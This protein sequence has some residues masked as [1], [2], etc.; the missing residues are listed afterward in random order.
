[1]V[2]IDLGEHQ[3]AVT[4]NR[5]PVPVITVGKNKPKPPGSTDTGAA[6][7]FNPRFNGEILQL[8][9]WRVS[10]YDP[11]TRTIKEKTRPYKTGPKGRVACQGSRVNAN[12]I[13]R[14]TIR[15]PPTDYARR[16]SNAPGRRVDR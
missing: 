2:H 11:G 12:L 5:Q 15:G 14:V 9:T 16:R 3:A 7:S 10:N 4:L 13:R 1:A 6:A 8:Q